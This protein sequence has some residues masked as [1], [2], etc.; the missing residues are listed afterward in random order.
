[1]SAD[2]NLINVIRKR[3]PCSFLYFRFCCAIYNKIPFPKIKN[4][5]DLTSK[6]YGITFI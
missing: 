1:M 2:I 5:S 6:K 4:R 3:I